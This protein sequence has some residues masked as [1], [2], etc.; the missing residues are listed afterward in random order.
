MYKTKEEITREF[1]KL[2]KYISKFQVIEDIKTVKDILNFI[3]KIREEDREEFEKEKED[4]ILR[5]KDFHF[6]LGKREAREE[7]KK[8]IGGCIEKQRNKWYGM[9]GMLDELL[10]KLKEK[11][12]I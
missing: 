1:K 8:E 2:T 12:L 3:H 11:N 4:I 5:R 6:E 10:E 7:I 9:E